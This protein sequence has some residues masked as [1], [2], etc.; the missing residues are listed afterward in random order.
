[1]IRLLQT[2]RSRT[3]PEYRGTVAG[4]SERFATVNTPFGR[5][6]LLRRELCLWYQRRPRKDAP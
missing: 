1:M 5:R 3:R 2:V 6:R 4:L